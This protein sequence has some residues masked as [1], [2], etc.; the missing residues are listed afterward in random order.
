MQTNSSSSQQT[1]PTGAGGQTS[2]ASHEVQQLIG[3]MNV[4]PE[5]KQLLT[6]KLQNRDHGHSLQ[7]KQVD[8]VFKELKTNR[9]GTHDSF[10]LDQLHKS[11]T[12]HMKTS[13]SLGST[14]RLSSRPTLT[15][16]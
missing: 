13:G 15:H 12:S 5:L 1:K 10:H 6:K 9:A 2:I 14:S 7:A 8:Q 3:R 16:L 11:I 4:S